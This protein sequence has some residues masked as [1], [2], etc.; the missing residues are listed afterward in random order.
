M[1]SMKKI[2]NVYAS[3]LY[4]IFSATIVPLALFVSQ[5]IIDKGQCG[6]SGVFDWLPGCYDVASDSTAIS[7]VS[8]AGVALSLVGLVIGAYL[9]VVLTRQ[10]FRNSKLKKTTSTEIAVLC[11]LAALLYFM[12]VLAFLG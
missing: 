12:I 6:P 1:I 8:I 5:A 9:T 4:L 7:N 2:N 11:F 10:N 3:T